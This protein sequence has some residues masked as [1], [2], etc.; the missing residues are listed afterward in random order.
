[1]KIMDFY[2]L[3]GIDSKMDLDRSDTIDQ[4]T[5]QSNCPVQIGTYT[6]PLSSRSFF[7]PVLLHTPVPTTG[8]PRALPASLLKACQLSYSS[9]ETERRGYLLQERINRS[10]QAH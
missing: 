1:M 4:G 6:L 3:Y 9:V 5:C 10:E 2:S 8:A 7:F